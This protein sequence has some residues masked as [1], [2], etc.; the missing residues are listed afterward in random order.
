[1]NATISRIV[2]IGPMTKETFCKRGARG[3]KSCSSVI[4]KGVPLELHNKRRNGWARL[5][6]PFGKG[7][8]RLSKRSGATH[9]RTIV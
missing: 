3:Q 2:L 4:K 5:K 7:R 8:E 6:K 1:M 9:E